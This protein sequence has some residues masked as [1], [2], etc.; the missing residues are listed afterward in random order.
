[1]VS[2]KKP[3]PAKVLKKTDIASKKQLELKVKK[4]EVANIIETIQIEPVKKKRTKYV[5]PSKYIT[6]TIISSCLDALQQ[7]AIQYKNKNA[8][9]ED[10]T[11]IFAELHC[12]K[13][14]NTRGNIKL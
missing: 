10:E 1:M 12:M 2:A 4:K 8:I 6:E 11:A 9:F 7:L 14:Q 13:I 5:M 3:K